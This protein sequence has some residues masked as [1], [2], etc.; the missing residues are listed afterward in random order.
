MSCLCFFLRTRQPEKPESPNARSK[1]SDC[2]HGLRSAEGGLPRDTQQQHSNSNSTFGS[3]DAQIHVFST[4]Q[5]V[6]LLGLS[7]TELTARTPST[8]RVQV[9]L[10]GQQNCQI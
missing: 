6:Q 1:P 2:G 9:R 10:L 3:D 5:E 4:P 7:T 8:L